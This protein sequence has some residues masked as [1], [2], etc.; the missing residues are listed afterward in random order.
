MLIIKDDFGGLDDPRFVAEW[1]DELDALT[2]RAINKAFKP[3]EG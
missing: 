3:T 2:A 1:R